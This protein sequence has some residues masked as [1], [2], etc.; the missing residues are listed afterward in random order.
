MHK[1]IFAILDKQKIYSKAV[2]CA[3]SVNTIR[4]KKRRRPERGDQ[5]PTRLAVE[6]MYENMR[7]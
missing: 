1:N 5:N 4:P 7:D 6:K 2:I 3:V